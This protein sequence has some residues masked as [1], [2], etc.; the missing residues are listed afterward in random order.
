MRLL[1][2]A[3]SPEKP[4]TR[5]R[6]TYYAPLFEQKGAQTKVLYFYEPW[7]NLIDEIRASDVTMISRKLLTWLKLRSV[8]KAA[9]TLVYDFDDAIWVKDRARI[10]PR[11][12]FVR[13]SR[14]S[15]LCRA[16][17]LVIAGSNSLFDAVPENSRQKSI[18]V[19]STADFADYRR[20]C[21][22]IASPAEKLVLGWIGTPSTMRY[23]IDVLPAIEAAAR[24]VPLALKVIC[25]EFPA[26]REFEQINVPWSS[27]VEA[28][29]LAGIDVGISPLD[30]RDKFNVWTSGKCALKAVQYAACAKPAIA[31]NQGAH[32]HI[33]E[34]ES[35]GF[36]VD[37]MED[38]MNAIVRA[39]ELKKSNALAKLGENYRANL[40]KEYD[41]RNAFEKIWSAILDLRK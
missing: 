4:S 28:E 31:Q 14:F 8:R 19:P 22:G 39:Y 38:W 20:R 29:E 37:T 41:R 32:P 12:S 30:A 2:I 5:Y 34:H 7:R 18:I 36:L 11:K 35:S 15:R 13:Y 1:F 23:L 3:S 24:K 27:R 6:L 16:A 26:P 21:E 33:I 10:A 25:S 9:K 17:D 40:E